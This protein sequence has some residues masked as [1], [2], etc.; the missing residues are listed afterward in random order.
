MFQG[1]QGNTWLNATV[2]IP[3]IANARQRVAIEGT[4][5]GGYLGDIAIDDIKIMKGYCP[6]KDEPVTTGITDTGICD[7]SCQN[8]SLNFSK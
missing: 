6:E 2:N 7:Q 8:Q 5:G 4:I 3:V 1:N